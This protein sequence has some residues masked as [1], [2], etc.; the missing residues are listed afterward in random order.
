MD[1]VMEAQ[2]IEWQKE[3]TDKVVELLYDGEGSCGVS[4]CSCYTITKDEF[5][6]ALREKLESG[7]DTLEEYDRLTFMVWESKDRN[8]HGSNHNLMSESDIILF[9]KAINRES[10]WDIYSIST[11]GMRQG[12]ADWKEETLYRKEETE[13]RKKIRESYKYRRKVGFN[14]SLKSKV[15]DR[16]NNE[17]TRCGYEEQL[18]VHHIKQLR[19]AGNN[20]MDNLITLCHD[21]H[22]KAHKLLRKGDVR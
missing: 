15:K 20:S 2:R 6:I 13:L 7:I 18:E 11:K 17:C 1:E 19:D 5:K 10:F 22:V 3:L 8:K 14:D 9:D 16:D 12:I 4:R 21:C